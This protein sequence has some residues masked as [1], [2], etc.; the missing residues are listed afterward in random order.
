M[1][2]GPAS[3]GIGRYKSPPGVGFSVRET[4]DESEAA[5]RGNGLIA[6]FL[7][8]LLPGLGQGFLGRWG[9]AVLFAIPIAI[10]AVSGFL[11]L[12]MN[13]FDL[14]GYAVRP[15]IL[16][17]V[18]VVNL[19]RANGYPISFLQFFKYGVVISIVTLLISTGYV[20]LRYFP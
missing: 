3:P 13:T 15:E 7:S 20:W 17:T 18:L 8:A 4:G 2:R 5:I 1:V 6:A 9:R 16:R 12:D 19:A 11:L 10:G 14:I